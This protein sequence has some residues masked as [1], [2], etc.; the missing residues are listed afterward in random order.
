MC[1]LPRKHST[2]WGVREEKAQSCLEM[3]VWE[4]WM[5]RG[6][7]F[8]WETRTAEYMARWTWLARDLVLA[9]LRGGD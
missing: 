6:L 1:L 9:L 5:I 2:N 3:T 4:R 8:G 7:T